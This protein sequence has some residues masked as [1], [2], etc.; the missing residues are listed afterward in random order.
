MSVQKLQIELESAKRKVVTDGYEMSLGEIASLYKNDELI[1]AP[2]YQRLIRWDESQKTRFIESI[3]LGLPVPPVFVFQ[4]EDGVWELIDGLQRISTALHL[5]GILK[6]DGVL[7]EPLVLSGTNFLPSLEGMKWASDQ[8]DDAKFFNIPLQ[9]EI[10]RARIRVEI[11]RKESDQDAKYELFQRLNTGGSKLS[12]QEVRNCVLVMLNENF[13]DWI[14]ERSIKNEFKNTLQLTP[15][16]QEL[17]QD[18]EMVLRFVAYRREAYTKGLDVN[19]YLDHAARK[20]SALTPDE[21]AEETEIFNWTFE[22][23]WKAFDGDAFKRWD[24]HRHTGRSMLAAFDVIAYGVAENRQ[25]I[26]TELNNEQRQEWLVKKVHDLW[27][28]ETYATYSG[29]GVRGTTRMAN[30]LPFAVNYFKP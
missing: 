4:R 30:L 23:L 14:R 19:E 13:F 28:D 6:V 15:T 12:D 5:M 26:M 10:K 7:R 1:I 16:Q 2:S 22:L 24:G 9:L 25:A 18:H 8:A 27:T 20:L 11:L 17:A 29:Q 3:L 21:L